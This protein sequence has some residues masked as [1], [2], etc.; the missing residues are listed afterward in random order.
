MSHWRPFAYVPR[1][2]ATDRSRPIELLF[3]IVFVLALS[4]VGRLMQHDSSL[5]GIARTVALLLL[6]WWPWN[7]MV[8]IACY[9]PSDEIRMKIG[10]LVATA[11][12]VQ[13]ALVAPEAFMDRPGGYDGPTV[14]VI[15]LIAARSIG[16]ALCWMLAFGAPRLR[17]NLVCLTVGAF[18]GYGLMFASLGTTGMTQVALLLGA[19]LVD[20]GGVCLTACPNTQAR[21]HFG[22]VEGWQIHST[23]IF[24]TRM[25]VA[26][27]VSL[28]QCLEFLDIIAQAKT[29]SAS[30]LVFLVTAVLIMYLLWRSYGDLLFPQAIS[31][32]APDSEKLTLGQKLALCIGGYHFVHAFM[33]GGVLVLAVNLQDEFAVLSDEG[34]AGT[35]DTGNLERMLAGLALVFACQAVFF[36]LVTRRFDPARLVLALACPV[37]IPPLV[38]APVLAV[39]ATVVAFGIALLW[40]DQTRYADLRGT[41]QPVPAARPAV[42]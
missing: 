19:A 40:W 24:C 6:L 8:T 29:I 20:I 37:A 35:V 38:G 18:I 41:A 15:A 11:V 34:V 12:F 10:T 5:L 16:V 17:G 23:Q 4:Q 33:I 36:F 9:L 28:S 26:Y 7:Q 1:L 14:F 39:A 3:D 13:L 21:F 42:A 32:L 22:L 30:L 2:T 31:V 27:L 25:K